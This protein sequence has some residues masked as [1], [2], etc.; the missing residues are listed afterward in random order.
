MLVGMTNEQGLWRFNFTVRVSALM[1]ACLLI[2]L[3]IYKRVTFRQY[4]KGGT[5]CSFYILVVEFIPFQN[6]LL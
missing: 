4:K 1:R 6:P 3:F 5:F 2:Y